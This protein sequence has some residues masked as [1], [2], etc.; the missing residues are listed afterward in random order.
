M[1]RYFLEAL[2]D[3]R[4]DRIQKC[5]TQ[6]QRDAYQVISSTRL[7]AMGGDNRQH[8]QERH[9]QPC[10]FLHGD[11]FTEKH[12]RQHHQD[13]RL[14]VVHRGAD[15]DG[16]TG[17]GFEQQQPVADNGHAAEHGQPQFC[18]TEQVQAQVT[19]PGAH[20]YQRQRTDHAA[21]E[22]H[23]DHRHARHQHKPANAARDQHGGDHFPRPATDG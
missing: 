13:K 21:P 16:G 10:Q 8:A 19:Q 15:S 6:G 17:I 2:D 20:Q 18:P 12:R 5:R 4:R 1:R 11:F 9:A 22:H 3:Q 14:H 7:V 23:L